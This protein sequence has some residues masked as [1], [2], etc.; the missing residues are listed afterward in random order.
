MKRRTTRWYLPVSLA[1]AVSTFGVVAGATI[2]LGQGTT[3]SPVPGAPR[4]SAGRASRAADHAVEPIDRLQPPT[5]LQAPRQF[6]AAELAAPLT[7]A[8]HAI[9]AADPGFDQFTRLRHTDVAEAASPDAVHRM[10]NARSCAECHR[11]GGIGGGGPNEN[12]VRLINRM[13]TTR[14][15]KLAAHFGPGF[16]VAV[17]HRQS[18]VPEYG[19]WRLAL[20]EKFAP[21][22]P[23][24]AERI[25]LRLKKV[26][27]GTE[28]AVGLFCCPAPPA[29]AFEQRN[30]PPLFGLGLIES[31]PQ[32]AI[33]AIAA[34]QPKELRGRS[35]RLQGG[36]HGRFGWKSSTATLAAFNENACAVELGLSTP[37]FTPDSFRPA[38]F[39]PVTS[40]LDVRA[41]PPK[42]PA[43][44]ATPDMSD[45]D[46]A[47]LNRFVADLPAP[48]QFIEP[49][50]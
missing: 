43:G 26:S 12:N 9:H 33:D 41:V 45:A 8:R 35:P 3:G 32:S 23:E 15:P 25:K 39:R 46:L 50:R 21:H 30:T 11:Q 7:L 48:R 49:D 42:G 38:M 18:L 14:V 2:F 5:S 40:G 6:I 29:V 1:A 47:A 36:G 34:S 16:G 22:D 27:D 17:M 24:V 20:I 19:E 44:S 31:I 13:V 28:Q 37:R 4:S 10:F